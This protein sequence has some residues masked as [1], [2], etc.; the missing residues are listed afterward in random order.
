MTR[1]L[2]INGDDFGLTPGVN[3]G[4]LEAHREGVLTSASIFASA[5]AT[6]QAIAIAHATP[7]LGVG[8]HLT[9]VDGVSTLPASEVPSLLMPD[10]R[11]RETWGTF[12]R[13]CLMGRVSLDEVRRELTAQIVK[14][15]AAG[16][17]LTHLDSHK[18]VHSY[19]PI[20]RIVAELA[21]TFGVPAVRVPYESPW[22]GPVP[23]DL[24]DG[25]IRRQAIENLA[26]RPWTQMDARILASHSRVPAAFFGRV[27]T[28]RLTVDV[29]AR[30]V[31]RLPNGVSE[32]MTHPGYS[33]AALD[34]V[35]TRL[36]REREQE[37]ALL[38]APDARQ[39]ILDAQ[40][41]LVRHDLRPVASF[42][43]G[44]HVSDS[45][46][47]QQSVVIREAITARERVIH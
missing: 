47:D 8:V 12:I 20:F 25:G 15:Q 24:R 43:G 31:S 41:T 28:G 29:L 13:A 42:I 16:L 1:L 34:L 17:V 7:S 19:P 36:R 5:P 46:S 26:L 10:G 38:R 6:D 27:H 2:V 37:V 23:G 33:D 14:L 11:F 35:R 30:I 3:A 32:L 44:G 22:L 9:L 40:V 39:A 4:M 45:V 18:H 21:T